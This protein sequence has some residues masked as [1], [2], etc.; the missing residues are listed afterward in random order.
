[1]LSVCPIPVRQATIPILA[2]AGLLAWTPPVRA[3]GFGVGARIAWVHP[4]VDADVDAVRYFGGQIRLVSQRIG[5]EVALDRHS[6]ELLNQKVTETPIQASIL[7][8]MAKGS[9]SPFLLGGPGWY[10]RKVETLDSPGDLSVS[11]TEFGWHAGVG[12]EVL[13]GKHFGFHGDYRYTFLN[14][15]D[16]NDAVLIGRVLP[17]HRGSM[18]TLGTT[19]YF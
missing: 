19:F 1:M 17:G 8:R 3:Q 7:L 11:T 12:L 5:F 9:V 10:R 13:A 18:W 14:F 15:H 2:L 6:E 16:D 4:D